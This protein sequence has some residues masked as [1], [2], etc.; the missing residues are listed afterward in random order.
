MNTFL[1]IYLVGFFVT[2]FTILFLAMMVYRGTNTVINVKQVI[3]LSLI[4]PASVPAMIAEFF[5]S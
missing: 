4:W 5:F 3:L 1:L 2:L